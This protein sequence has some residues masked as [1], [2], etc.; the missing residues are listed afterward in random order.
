M[1]ERTQTDTAADEVHSEPAPSPGPELREE[2]D[3]ARSWLGTL[4]RVFSM[5]GLALL[6]CGAITLILMLVGAFAYTQLGPGGVM[7]Q[8]RVG[9]P[10][11]DFELPLLNGGTARLSDYRGNIVALNF[12]A[13]YCRRCEKELPALEAAA[14]EFADEGLVVLTVNPRQKI[15]HIREYLAQQGVTL[16]IAM[17]AYDEVWRKY[18]IVALPTTVFIDREGIVHA[19]ELDVLTPELIEK[20]VREMNSPGVE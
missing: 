3:E 10:A 2:K 16:T 11:P 18:R 6:A 13:T 5:L 9:E 7:S 17:D 8:V 15:S 4:V 20:Y 1:A 19:V 12:W 14:E